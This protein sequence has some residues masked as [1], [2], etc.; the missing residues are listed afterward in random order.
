[1]LKHHGVASLISRC[2]AA[3][4]VKRNVSC[5]DK[6]R[7][8]IK[9]TRKGNFCLE[10]LARLHRGELLSLRGDFAVPSDGK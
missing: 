5:S 1:L 7:V 2:E 6:R 8:E 4:L 10:K 9:L 3:G